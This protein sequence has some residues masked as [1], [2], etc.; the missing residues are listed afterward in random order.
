M[1]RYYLSVNFPT[2]PNGA[3]SVESCTGFTKFETY[4]LAHHTLVKSGWISLRYRERRLNHSPLVS[5][6][7]VQ[8]KTMHVCIPLIAYTTRSPSNGKGACNFARGQYR[9]RNSNM[10]DVL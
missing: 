9:R 1:D 5:T 6:C 4:S 8:P 2:P 3:N 10:A 7:S